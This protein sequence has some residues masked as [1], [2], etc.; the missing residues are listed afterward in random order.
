MSQA[1]KSFLSLTIIN[2]FLRRS[3]PLRT[4]IDGLVIA[5]EAVIDRLDIVEAGLRHLAA[6]PPQAN[7]ITSEAVAA[8]LSPR[9]P[10]ACLQCVKAGPG[11]QCVWTGK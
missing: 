1:E 6:E 11:V 2:P 4:S 3:A 8:I 10:D 5:L 7:R 9:R